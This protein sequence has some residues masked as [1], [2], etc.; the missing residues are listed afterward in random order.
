M[1]A[2]KVRQQN[3]AFQS[4]ANLSLGVAVVIVA[5]PLLQCFTQVP[6]GHV[7]VGDFFGIVSKETLP[8]GIRFVNPLARVIKISIR[9]NEHSECYIA[10]RDLSRH[11]GRALTERAPALFL[12]RH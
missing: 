1:A 11:F 5:L 2:T 4:A 10:P 7:G 8:S 9:T 12:H 6:A 3:L